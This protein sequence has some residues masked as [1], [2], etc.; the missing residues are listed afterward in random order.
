MADGM[1]L[2]SNTLTAA[3]AAVAVYAQIMPSLP[4]VRRA[5]A[6]S[7]V[8][9][10]VRN[11]LMVGSALLLGIGALISAHERS[12]RPL[13][14]MAGTAA[15][16]ALAYEG[17]LRRRGGRAVTAEPGPAAVRSLGRYGL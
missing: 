4:E 10:D 6:E 3:L 1:D 7:A 11:G 5:S 16:L 14:I 2:G 13:L 9:E 8:G 12:R 15:M 17:T